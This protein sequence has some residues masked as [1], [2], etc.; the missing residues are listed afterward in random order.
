MNA[1][2]H[3]NTIGAMLLC[4]L[5]MG[6]FFDAYRVACYRFSVS[7]WMIPGFDIAYWMLATF[8][9]FHT[10]L[11]S[12]FGEVRVYVFLGIGIGISGYF[13]LLSPKVLKVIRFL[14]RVVEQTALGVWRTVR[15]IVIVPL[16]WLT[17]VLAWIMET[18]FIV[19]AVIVLWTLR[20]LAKPLGGLGRW[21]W[22]R[23]LPVRRML[24][25]AVR[26]AGRA[27]DKWRQI[28]EVFRRKS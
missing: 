24:S 7:R 27:R 9:V 12:N 26:W 8:M 4:G 5:A 6:V 22:T 23:L 17:R 1:A 14:F 19:T 13:A 25:P 16:L 11:N 2:M 15:A 21:L 3:W 20:L 10:L 28:K 18:L